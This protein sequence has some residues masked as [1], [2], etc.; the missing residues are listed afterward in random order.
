M[1]VQCCLISVI[2]SLKYFLAVFR[3]LSQRPTPEELEQRN[4]LKRELMRSRM[5]VVPSTCFLKTIRV[6]N[7][8]CSAKPTI[9]KTSN[10][11]KLQL[12]LYRIEHI[13][14]LNVL[15]FGVYEMPYPQ[16]AMKKCSKSIMFSPM[17]VE[18]MFLGNQLSLSL[19]INLYS[20]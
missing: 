4:I 12:L 2:L 10:C 5:P 7:K 20:H 14:M 15:H 17:W 19:L 3:R 1:S 8:A 18:G 9:I 13:D 11:W 6:A 16:L